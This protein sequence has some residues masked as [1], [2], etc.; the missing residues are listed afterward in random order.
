MSA[1]ASAADTAKPSDIVPERKSPA[2]ASATRKPSPARPQTTDTAIGTQS[3]QQ[4]GGVGGRHGLRSFGSHMPI[5]I[6][7]AD[8]PDGQRPCR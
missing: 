5:T 7:A 1:T 3:I 2:A 4:N 8:Q 6:V